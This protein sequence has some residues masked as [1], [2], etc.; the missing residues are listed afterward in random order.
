ML[1]LLQDL[2]LAVRPCQ[3][4]FVSSSNGVPFDCNDSIVRCNSERA[5]Q[6]DNSQT[7]VQGLAR[8]CGDA[9]I[10]VLSSRLVGAKD[11]GVDAPERFDVVV[12]PV[13][14]VG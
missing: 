3:G 5:L 10:V 6:C 12:Y 11:S 1:H 4:L 9:H 14:L 7:T 2:N 8:H 13:E